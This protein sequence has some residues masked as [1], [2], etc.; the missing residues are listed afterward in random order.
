[1]RFS[2]SARSL[3]ACSENSGSPVT[4]R[5]T[6]AQISGASDGEREQVEAEARD[7]GR[8][9][10][11]APQPVRP[12]RAPT[13]RGAAARPPRAGPSPARPRRGAPG[14]ERRRP[15]DERQERDVDVRARGV[16]QEGE[17]RPDEQRAEQA[18]PAARTPPRPRGT[19]PT[20]ARR[21]ESEQMSTSRRSASVPT[22]PTTAHSSEEQRVLRRRGVGGE[23]RLHAVRAAPGP[24]RGGSRCR[25]SDRSGRAAH[26]TTVA[27]ASAPTTIHSARA[28]RTA[29]ARAGAAAAV[30]ALVLMPS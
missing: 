8:G 16:E 5:S 11:D 18:R 24:R 19:S 10:P 3:V 21:G 23:R 25:S 2:S 20:R 29:P 22:S 14:L 6:P 7:R 28:E 15:Q 13:P 27:R 1:M 12:G 26:A 17:A 9:G 30:P 4:H